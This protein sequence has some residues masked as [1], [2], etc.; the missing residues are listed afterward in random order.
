MSSDARDAGSRDVPGSGWVAG[1]GGI[2]AFPRSRG[3]QFS[4]RRRGRVRGG[5]VLAVLLSAG[6]ANAVSVSVG[7]THACAVLNDGK[8]M[9]WGNNANGELGIGTKGGHTS[10]PMNV[11]LGSGRTAKAVAC[12][13][14]HTCAILDDDNLKCWGQNS[15]G[16]LGYGDTTWR[17]APEATAVV[18]LGAGRKAKAVSAGYQHTCAILDDDT[19]KCWGYANLYV[20][21]YGYTTDKYAPEATAVVNLGSGRKAKT[22]TSGWGSDKRFV[23]ATLDDDSVKCWGSNSEGQLGRTPYGIH[24]Y[25][26]SPVAVTLGAGAASLSVGKSCFTCAALN[27]GT[28]KCWGRNQEGQIGQGTVSTAPITA[29]SVVNIGS[30]RTAK[31]VAAGSGN[32]CAILDDDSMKCW[33]ENDYGVLGTGNVLYSSNNLPTGVALP[34]GRTAKSVSMGSLNVC[35]VL[36]DDSIWCW[37]GNGYGQLGNG[38]DQTLHDKSPSP[39]RVCITADDCAAP[40]GPP[41][42]PG[43]D[44]SPGAAGAPGSPGTDGAAGAPGSPGSDGAAGASGASSSSPSPSGNNTVYVYVNVSGPPGPPGPPGPGLDAY[45]DAEGNPVNAADR[46]VASLPMLALSTVLYMLFY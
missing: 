10:N 30:G 20:L 39:T 14:T 25:Q 26:Q 16:W 13:Y 40:S 38:V 21:G 18:N 35:A 27:D 7:Y 36:D 28:V 32:A 15:Q 33:G 41:G 11:D 45:I 23:C 17:T 2:F 22:V 37:G 3:A 19:L 8:L 5:A 46:R 1:T 29:P 42:P 24:E 44:G 9:C 6:G 4:P 34:S 12:G 43:N 31:S